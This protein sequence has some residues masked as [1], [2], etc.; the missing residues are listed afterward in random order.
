MCIRD[1]Y[2][3]S[4]TTGNPKSVVFSHKNMLSNISSICRGFK[5]NEQEI[6]LII[7]PMGHTASVN[8]SFLPC[9]LLGGTLLITESF[10]KIRQNFWD[11]VKKFSITYVEVVPAILVALL[12]TPYD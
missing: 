11:L 2:Y 4:G 3:S 8:Y 7:L 6:H 9:T 5:F 1:S 12:I 10:W